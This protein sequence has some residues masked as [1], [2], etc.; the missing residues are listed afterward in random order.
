MLPFQKCLG[1]VLF[2]DR[3]CSWGTR[4][5]IPRIV[6]ATCEIPTGENI[7]EHET[8][9]ESQDVGPATTI[10]ANTGAVAGHD[11]TGGVVTQLQSKNNPLRSMKVAKTKIVNFTST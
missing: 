8:S 6:V 5:R 9:V 7:T 10:H 2:S 1:N 4:T 3:K 11:N